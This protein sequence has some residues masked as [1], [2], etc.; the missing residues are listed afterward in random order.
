M[1]D[2]YQ[3]A[4]ATILEDITGGQNKKEFGLEVHPPDGPAFRAIASYHLPFRSARKPRVGDVV[5][6]KYHPKSR[7][8]KLDVKDDV[9]YGM[10]REALERQFKRQEAQARR[11]ALLATPPGM[12]LSSSNLLFTLTG[13]TYPV[14]AVAWS[15][16]GRRLASVSDTMRIWNVAHGQPLLELELDSEEGIVQCLAWSPD[17]R[18]VAFCSENTHLWDAT[19]GKRYPPLIKPVPPLDVDES[20]SVAWSPGSRSLALGDKMGRISFWDAS[21]RTQLATLEGHTKDVTS[22]AWS[23]DGRMLASGS[24]DKTVRLWDV[25][26]GQT[27]TTISVPLTACS[28]AWSP[29]GRLLAGA[30]GYEPLLWDAATGKQLISKWVGHDNIWQVAWSPDGHLLASGSYDKTVRLWRVGEG[31][32]GAAISSERSGK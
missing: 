6:V 2:K 18:L 17:G 28:V 7:K 27:L 8:V 12:P 26:A 9:R 30:V 24:A 11:A 16:D 1:F 22:V 13:H 25:S 4:E 19:T 21:T 3:S 20:N 32:M 31:E 5:K 29:D 14:Y 10:K 15:P 23:P